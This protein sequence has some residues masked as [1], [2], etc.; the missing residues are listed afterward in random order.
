VTVWRWV[1]KSDGE[2]MTVLRVDHYL[3]RDDIV[4]LLCA[5][6]APTGVPFNHQ[7]TLAD[8]RSTLASA[9]EALDALTMWAETR[10][11]GDEAAARLEWA[12]GLAARL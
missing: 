8:V 2:P 3:T 6:A 4:T 1:R 7:E 9:W 11:S 5:G 10:Y 12:R